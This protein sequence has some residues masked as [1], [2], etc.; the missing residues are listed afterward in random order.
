MLVQ[1]N[2]ECWAVVCTRR[3]QQKAHDF[4]TMMKQVC[5]SFGMEINDPLCLLL[6]NDRTENYLRSIR[7]SVQSEVSEQ[8]SVLC[9]DWCARSMCNIPWTI[10][11]TRGM[12]LH[13][14]VH[15]TS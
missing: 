9:L 13:L 14:R 4:V 5:P 8:W 11:R 2:L 3:D 7:E 6:D 12:T 1:V 15:D 10:R